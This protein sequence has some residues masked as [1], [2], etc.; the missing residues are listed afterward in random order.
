MLID[1]CPTYV[2]KE[3]MQCDAVAV[4]NFGKKLG[5][6]SKIRTT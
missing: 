6:E 2:I 5:L 4:G 1:T 3:V